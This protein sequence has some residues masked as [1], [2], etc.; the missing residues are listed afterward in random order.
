MIANWDWVEDA[1]WEIENKMNNENKET[2][3]ERVP[4]GECLSLN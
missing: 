2:M 3:M 1:K 4:K